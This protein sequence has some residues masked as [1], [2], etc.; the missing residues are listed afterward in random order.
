MRR[1]F[2]ALVF[3][4]A[5]VAGCHK[6]PAPAAPPARV[7]LWE[8]SNSQ[9]PR[10]WLFG[11][12]HALPAGVRWRDGAI[13][14]ALASA[15]QLVFEIAQ[16]IDAASAG[17]VLQQLGRSD[18]LPPPSE[19]IAPDRVA[20]LQAVYRKLGVSDANFAGEESWAVAL[21]LAA[22]G[23]RSEG[24]DPDNG[25]E[26][27]LRKAAAG[28]QVTGLET[29]AGQFGAF[30]GLP[31]RAQSVLLGEVA[32]EA[33]TDA[34]S[35]ADMMALWLKGDVGGIGRESF[36]GFLANPE[37]RTALLTARTAR[38]AQEIDAMIM[39]GHRPF[40]AVG[41]AHVAGPDG[42]PALMAQ[43]GYTVRRVQ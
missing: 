23:S 11:T 29:L 28:K 43:R 34:D 19:R 8:V 40:V 9:G 30:D 12:V 21:Q 14:K 17:A 15:D 32:H 42:L 41:A 36:K 35:E 26:P 24:I 1:R 33:A 10:A 5:L 3:A 20:D 25:V 7:A 37:V 22:A 38:W 27:E 13:D 16:P 4:L 39:A 6:P 31:P 18:G 2:A